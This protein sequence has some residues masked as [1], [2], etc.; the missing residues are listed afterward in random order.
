MCIGSTEI[1]H[2]SGLGI[3][4]LISARGRRSICNF[5]VPVVMSVFL[6]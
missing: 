6:S 3:R 1:F 4:P 5:S 2:L